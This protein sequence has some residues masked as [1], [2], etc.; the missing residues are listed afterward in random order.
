MRALVIT[1][2]V[3]VAVMMGMGAVAPMIQQAEAT[4][5]NF[6]SLKACVALSKIIDPPPEVQHLLDQHCL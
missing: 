2:I 4:P 6:I 1:A 3:L 5:A